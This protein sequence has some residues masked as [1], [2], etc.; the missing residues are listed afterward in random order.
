MG[1]MTRSSMVFVVKLTYSRR[2]VY[3]ACT[4]PG[5]NEYVARTLCACRISSMVFT[6]YLPV[7]SEPAHM[8]FQS[9]RCSSWRVLVRRY[10]LSASSTPLWGQEGPAYTG[11]RRG[12]TLIQVSN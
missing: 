11:P 1:S 10:R 7:G 12:G 2:S 6:F 8:V 3:P 5:V 9:T 4:P